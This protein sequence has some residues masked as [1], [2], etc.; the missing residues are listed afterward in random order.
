MRG[1][2]FT[3]RQSRLTAVQ[4]DLRLPNQGSRALYR[5][6]VGVLWAGA[7]RGQLLRLAEGHW[8]AVPVPDV[9]TAILS[10][11]GDSAG[12]PWVGTYSEFQASA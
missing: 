6:R 2:L 3:Y 11:G 12:V 7:P 4:M 9:G 10:L 1:P 5:D 8:S